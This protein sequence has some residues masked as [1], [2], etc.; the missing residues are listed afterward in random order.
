MQCRSIKLWGCKWR[1]QYLCFQQYFLEMYS[2]PLSVGRISSAQDKA[3]ALF[4]ALYPVEQVLDPCPELK[5]VYSNRTVGET[6]EK[7][8]WMYALAGKL[9]SLRGCGRKEST[10]KIGMRPSV[11]SAYMLHLDSTRREAGR[12]QKNHW[13][14]T[15]WRE[16]AAAE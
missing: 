5:P 14:E 9:E 12:C 11:L 15:P 3:P 1:I 6:R 16:A 8:G 7:E 2:R 10:G 13:A 4:Q